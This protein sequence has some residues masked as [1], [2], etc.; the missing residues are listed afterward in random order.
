MS[1]RTHHIENR[2]KLRQMMM[3][4]KSL[5]FMD[6][7]DEMCEKLIEFYRQ[8]WNGKFLYGESS[9]F[10][11]ILQWI[12]DTRDSDTN[13]IAFGVNST[14]FLSHLFTRHLNRILRV[15]NTLKFSPHSFL[16]LTVIG[17]PGAKVI[18]DIELKSVKIDDHLF[19]KEFLSSIRSVK[20][21]GQVGKFLL[22]GEEVNFVSTKGKS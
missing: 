7:I 16:T 20:W 3:M 1:C 5:K 6:H 17:L 13:S 2:I 9:I 15:L 18:D 11:N 8:S 22:C 19:T 4:T 14:S 21:R 12:A 10:I